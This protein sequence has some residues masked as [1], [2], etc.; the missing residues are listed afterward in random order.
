MFSSTKSC[1]SMTL[2]PLNRAQKVWVYPQIPWEP[3]TTLQEPMI[4][5]SKLLQLVTFPII[6]R[7]FHHSQCLRLQI[8]S[9]WVVQPR[10]PSVSCSSSKEVYPDLQPSFH[11]IPQLPHHVSTLC[12]R[13]YPHHSSSFSYLMMR[14]T[15]MLSFEQILS[16]RLQHIRLW[17]LE[18]TSGALTLFM[19][20][21]ESSQF[22]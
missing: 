5:E 17:L 19:L 3:S 6:M 13:I 9:Y 16:H 7:V 10:S 8:R 12:S 22:G 18:C 20:N 15:S 1:K 14:D 21:G 2:S 11:Y 4:S